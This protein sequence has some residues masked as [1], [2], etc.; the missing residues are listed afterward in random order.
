MKRRGRLA[1]EYAY[2]ARAAT[3]SYTKYLDLCW[4][5]L[6]VPGTECNLKRNWSIAHVDI[7]R[8]SLETSNPQSSECEPCLYS[9]PFHGTGTHDGETGPDRDVTSVHSPKITGTMKRWLSSHEHY[10]IHS[11]PASTRATQIVARIAGH[12]FPHRRRSRDAGF[13]P[14]ILNVSC[15]GR[16]EGW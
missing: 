12:S 1:D 8:A 14:A 13:L 6:H 9:L 7:D 15:F 2:L 5:Y 11:L 3:V 4:R 10:S 16:H